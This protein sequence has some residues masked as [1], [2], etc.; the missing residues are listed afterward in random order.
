MTADGL[1]FE[2]SAPNTYVV[3]GSAT[4]LDIQ[5]FNAEKGMGP[6]GR[7]TTAIMPSTD[8]AE[9]LR[10]AGGVYLTDDYVPADNLI[11]PIFAER[12]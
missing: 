1:L 3:A 9:Y 10:T 7:V 5:R 8:L 11:A 2:S 12:Y 6:G 4:P